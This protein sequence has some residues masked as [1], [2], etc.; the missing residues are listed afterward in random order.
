MPCHTSDTKGEVKLG[1]EGDQ[2]EK[3]LRKGKD[4]GVDMTKVPD[5]LK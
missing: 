4:A 5:V 2:R 1:G 3:G